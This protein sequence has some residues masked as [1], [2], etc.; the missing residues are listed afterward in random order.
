MSETKDLLF[1]LGCEELPPTSLRKLSDALSDHVTRGLQE[2]GLSFSSVHAYAT[3]RR[4]ALWLESV[5]IKQTDRT[6]EK[7]GPALKA[8]YD[9]AG[10]PTKATLGFL[11]GCGSDVTVD[12]LQTL[13]TD[14]G[15]WLMFRQQEAGQDAESLIPDILKRSLAALPIAKRMRWGSREDE[16][17]RP[18]HWVVLLFGEQVI[19]TQILGVATGNRTWG[20]RFH[21]NTAIDVTAPKDYAGILQQQGRV[22]VDFDARRALIQQQAQAAA[23]DVNGQAVIDP[24]LL[25]E[26]T[27]LV[28]W[29]VAIT[30]KFDQRFLTLP[31][32]ALITSMQ[33][34]QKYF[35]VTDAEH[36]LLP[37]F[38]TISNIES[39][40]P[41]SVR[42]G[43][44]RVI[45][46]RLADAEFFW[47]Q[48][49]KV[50]L[51]QRVDDLDNIVFQKTLGT[52][53]DKTRRMEC[54]ADYLANSL[55]GDAEH[56]VRAAQLA[57]TDLLTQMVGEFA[58]LQ[59]IMG[60]YYAQADGEPED[61]A[62][63]IEEHYFPKQA[64]A[65][66]PSEKTGQILAIADKIDTIVGIFSVGL[67]PSG[68]KDPYA[69]RRSALGVLRILVEKNLDLDL[70][71]LIRVAQQQFTHA[72][73]Q[74]QNCDQVSG[75][76]LDRFRGYCLSRGYTAE[77]F[78]AVARVAP[79]KPAEFDLRLQAVRE[80][81]GLPESDSLCAANKRIQ[82][83]LRKSGQMPTNSFDPTQ[84]IEPAE[85][86]LLSQLERIE[87]S[88]SPKIAQRHYTEAL[89]DLSELRQPVDQFFDDIL[90]MA[91]DPELRQARVSLLHR[92]QQN[93]IKIADISVI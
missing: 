75:F 21:A 74:A 80:F 81:T 46:P 23:A 16:F 70:Q 39:S 42:H 22:M 67:V 13:K 36:A 71:E 91:D 51:Q 79:L 58:S 14:K 37:C 9:D 41:E 6:V 73:D 66:L 12:Q 7:R 63:A 65:A 28:E 34:N 82:N 43:N 60:R 19:G 89:K 59:G 69:L 31:K 53:R 3:P 54:L 61:V 48:D 55:G 86:N 56:A 8:A 52:M 44:E 29:P 45:R 4:L 87:T 92:L 27:A 40:N 78:D 49:R 72:F 83:I 11:R 68:D 2:A 30:G 93:F 57:K 62:T 18:V 32:E 24:D 1:E 33:T 47:Q 76:F 64:G 50:E 20:H 17:V 5:S 10:Q 38:I 85:Q 26:V 25:D 77:Q 90:V 84:L 35:P 88:V 15:E